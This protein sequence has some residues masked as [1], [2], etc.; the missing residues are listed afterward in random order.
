MDNG[1]MLLVGLH[2]Y[3]WCGWDETN[4]IASGGKDINNHVESRI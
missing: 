1:N 3:R 4:P 2:L